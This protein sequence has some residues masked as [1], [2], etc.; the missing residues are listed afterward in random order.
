MSKLKLLTASLMTTALA[1][2]ALIAAACNKTTS[3]KAGLQKQILKKT[4]TKNQI[5]TSIT[6]LYL[7][8]FYKNDLQKLTKAELESKDVILKALNN[9][10]T[11]LYKEIYE[12]FKIY[13]YQQ[14]DKNPQFFSNLKQDFIDANIDTTNFSPSPF[15]MPTEEQF[16]FMINKGEYISTNIRTELQK[17]LVTRNY[18]LKDRAEL[19]ALANDKDGDDK[20]KK[21]VKIDKDK[22]PTLEK[23]IHE[24]LN[25][26]DNNLHLLEY[27]VRNPISQTWGFTDN[28][29]LQVRREKGKV[30]TF[31]EF[32]AL[33]KYNPDNKPLYETNQK[34]KHP[35][36]VLNTGDSEG[37]DIKNLNAYKGFEKAKSGTADLD[38]TL[39]AIKNQKSSIFGFV[40]PNTSKVYSMDS[41]K[42]ASILEQEK[43]TSKVNFTSQAKTDL[44]NGKK[45]NITA[46]DLELEGTT[47]TKEGDK[48][49]FTKTVTVNSKTY[50]LEYRVDS[51]NYDLK[52]SKD[53]QAKFTLTVKE[54]EKRNVFEFT[55][56]L[57]N[58]EKETKGTEFNLFKYPKSVDMLKT[59]GKSFDAKYITKI[60]PSWTKNETTKKMELS[61]RDTPWNTDEKIK[62]IANNL[63]LLD[64]SALFKSAVKYYKE[65]GFQIDE[66]NIN[67]EIK[68]ML[69]QEGIL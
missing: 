54:L 33:A 63:L 37:Y 30:S 46:E 3:D 25:F 38:Y 51:I 1:P 34:A 7:Q 44:D 53:V 17:M 59:D 27:L 67:E 50:T 15:Q 20:V 41:F 13:A 18:L 66:T 26:K 56:S 42:F 22:T 69:K 10:T 65:L 2:T 29:D 64:L 39:A 61:F 68:S 23:E 28:R 60:V 12:L 58:F 4:I 36:M 8:E 62:K 21:T 6:N 31:D 24:S 19:R 14:L 16:N 57:K 32:N 45:T 47:K 55:A 48:Y 9:K 5:I 40:D 52:K 49:V 35:E 11:D 43:E